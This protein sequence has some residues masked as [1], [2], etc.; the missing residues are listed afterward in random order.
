MNQEIVERVQSA[1]AH[2]A[3]FPPGSDG[4]EYLCAQAEFHDALEEARKPATTE[5]PQPVHAWFELSYAS[6]LTVP[7]AVLQS[8]PYSWQRRFVQ[9]LR[10]MDRAIEW[11]PP[12]GLRYR[13]MLFKVDEAAE[14]EDPYWIEEMSDPLDSYNRGRRRMPYK[15]PLCS[16][17][18][19]DARI[20]KRCRKLSADCTC[21]DQDA[22]RAGECIR[23]PCPSPL[24][25]KA[26]A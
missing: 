12:S 16:S 18:E 14:G 13:V 7:R 4:T 22:I 21:M 8:M 15:C 11:R 1:A 9:C 25:P 26:E 24:H 19:P 17:A 6:Y 3:S 20:C 2:L 5:K 23:I 10:E